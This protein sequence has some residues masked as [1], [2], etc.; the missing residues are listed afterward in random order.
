MFSLNPP[1]LYCIVSTLTNASWVFDLSSFKIFCRTLKSHVLLFLLR[2]RTRSINFHWFII[3]VVTGISDS[4]HTCSLIK[5]KCCLV[6]SK[7]CFIRGIKL[8]FGC[9][10][11]NNIVICSID[12]LSF[13]FLTGRKKILC[14]KFDL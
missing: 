1:Y 12:I 9:K 13:A 14:P 8:Q 6:N 10:H 3:L 5:M 7:L 11:S 2:T 4:L